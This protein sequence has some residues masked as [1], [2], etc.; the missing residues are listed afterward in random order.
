MALEEII[1]RAGLQV[2]DRHEIPGRDPR[3]APVPSRLHPTVA[4]VISKKHAQGL[5]AHQAAAMEASL[6][7]NDVC[8][9]TSTA[10]GKSDVFMSLA[11]DLLQRDATGRAL[12]LYP[13]RALIQDQIQKW[14][15]LLDPHSQPGFIDGSVPVPER[16][17]VLQ[18]H[19]VV[20]MTPDTLHAWFMSHLTDPQVEV[21][22][23]N[24]KLLILDEAHVY[25]GVF[26]TNMAF[27]LRRLEAVS[28]PFRLICTTATLDK[29]ADFMQ[30]LTGRDAAVLGVDE[31]GARISSKTI[32]LAQCARD[33]FETSSRLLKSLANE[34]EGRFI[35]FADS[36]RMVERLTSAAYRQFE[37]ASAEKREDEPPADET[38]RR[39][40]PYRAGYES[41]DRNLIQQALARGLLR[42]V[43]STSALE[44]GLDIGA[45]DLVVM[46]TR[47][48]SMKE[49]WQRL[50]RAGRGG[51]GTC[52]LLDSAGA[53][54]IPE[55]SLPRYLQ[56]PMEP[57]WLYLPNRYSQYAN[58]LCAAA[59][60]KACGSTVPA[61]AFATLPKTFLTCL[62]DA[63]VP[64]QNVPADLYPL[65][66]NADEMGPHH[67]FPL[68]DATEPS[69]R[70]E[71]EQRRLGTLS[72]SQAMRE[73]YPGAVYYHMARAY[74][75][76]GF[77]LSKRKILVRSERHWTT[78]PQWQSMVFPDFGA[79]LLKLFTSGT[80][81]M[82]ECEM[83][84]SER[85][86]GFREKHG[87]TESVVSYRPGNPFSE[88]DITRWIRTTGVCWHFPEAF[89]NTD[90][91]ARRLR[92]AFCLEFGVRTHD[93]G[94]SS[95]HARQSP[96]DAETCAGMCIFDAAPG[97]LRLTERL[98]EHFLKVHPARA[99]L[100]VA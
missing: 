47:P 75:V 82:G 27:L 40:L 89:A 70:V 37:P 31:E 39:L 90:A 83:Q 64:A 19:R 92:D 100:R 26:G 8:L 30:Q 91:V 25:D 80:G 74:R 46:L 15:V 11:A 86:S 53:A 24:L 10:S 43:V 4:E 85:V 29:P 2:I 67:A 96:I 41:E 62:D 34:H 35:A 55:N 88:R 9:A 84:V 54:P 61:P 58:A 3:F 16:S 97:S 18:R 87:D 14:K 50:G 93:L 77:S 48:P 49:F 23:K 56:R 17:Q 99:P 72:L 60:M 51:E 66:K 73:A 12:A 79:G 69:L 76:I 42:G 94:L 78:Y 32:L 52:L 36:R 71:S 28:S 95:F 22:R 68:R 38:F 7:G 6:G 1:Q 44:L 45:V 20:L 81:F 59:E 98:A 57:N 5:Y 13:V 33:V 65:R 63:L 21:F